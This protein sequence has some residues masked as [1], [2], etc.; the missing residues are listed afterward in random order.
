M[1]TLENLNREEWFWTLSEWVESVPES[2]LIFQDL[3]ID[4]IKYFDYN[5]IEYHDLHPNKNI[6]LVWEKLKNMED[7]RASTTRDLRDSRIPELIV[8]TNKI[9]HSYFR[10]AIP[11]LNQL[12]NRMHKSYL[13]HYPGMDQIKQ[14]FASFAKAWIKHLFLEERQLYPAFV[15]LG[16]E[17]YLSSDYGSFTNA[18]KLMKKDHLK[19]IEQ[20]NLICNDIDRLDLAH[21][22]NHPLS[23]LK[24]KLANFRS[25]VHKHVEIQDN[26][27]FPK[28]L[29][30]QN[31][32]IR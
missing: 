17:G 24:L 23:Y 20:L 3:G 30:L 25:Y 22:K 27:L 1:M 19:S 5:L 8:Q 7:L 14:H 10:H 31:S 26:I 15:Q 11:I 6:D 9:Q 4:Y 29:N 16:E 32:K 21:V 18:L 2:M 28:A 12:I 13:K